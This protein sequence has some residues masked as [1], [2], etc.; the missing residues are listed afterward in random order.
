[1]FFLESFVYIS[2]NSRVKLALSTLFYL[3]GR[4]LNVSV[5][6][7]ISLSIVADEKFLKLLSSYLA[8]KKNLSGQLI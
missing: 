1:M 7:F 5:S 2:S 8:F 4:E 3:T 6:V